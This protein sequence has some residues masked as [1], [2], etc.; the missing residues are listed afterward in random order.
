MNR[1]AASFVNVVKR[2]S[3]IAPPPIVPRIIR[4]TIIFSRLHS[5]QIVHRAYLPI[6]TA[7]CPILIKIRKISSRFAFPRQMISTL[8]NV[9]ANVTKRGARS[10]CLTVLTRI[11]SEGVSS[12]RGIIIVR[13]NTSV[14][15]EYEDFPRER[16]WTEPFGIGR[17]YI[18]AYR[19]Q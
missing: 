19:S 18:C 13:R 3:F 17:P 11:K 7:L 8:S 4:D 15:G 12:G 10:G 14:R 16:R 6:F 5:I 1:I 9:V 2:P